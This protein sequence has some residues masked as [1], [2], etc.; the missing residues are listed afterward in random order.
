M[1]IEAVKA[2]SFATTAKLV[3]TWFGAVVMQDPSLAKVCRG[4]EWW[5]CVLMLAIDV[6][7]ASANSCCCFRG[8]RSD[9]SGC[10]ILQPYQ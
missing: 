10:A 2:F 8:R 1:V 6:T 7:L 3:A 9:M 5:Y 4:A